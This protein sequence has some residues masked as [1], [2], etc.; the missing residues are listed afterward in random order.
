LLVQPNEFKSDKLINPY[1]LPSSELRRSVDVVMLH[2]LFHKYVT[3]I[4]STLCRIGRI[5]AFDKV[6][7][8]SPSADLDAHHLDFLVGS[9]SIALQDGDDVV[10]LVGRGLKESIKSRV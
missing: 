2:A 8:S 4:A 10:Q 5:L 1:K 9:R 7:D 3:N 6:C